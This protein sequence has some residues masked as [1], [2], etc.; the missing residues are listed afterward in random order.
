MIEKLY[1]VSRVKLE[2]FNQCIFEQVARIARLD[3]V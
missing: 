1:Y 3:D 2:G